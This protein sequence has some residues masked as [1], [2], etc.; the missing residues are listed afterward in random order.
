MLLDI[1]AG[2]IFAAVIPHRLRSRVPQAPYSFVNYGVRVLGSIAGGVLGS[3]IGLRPALWIGAAGRAVAVC[4]A[5]CP[6]PSAAAERA[7]S[8][9]GRRLT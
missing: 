7:A 4:F 8:D 2:S 5:S 9:G 3:A 6:P 1:S